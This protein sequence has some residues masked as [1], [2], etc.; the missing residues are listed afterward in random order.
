M[1]QVIA[2]SRK[3]LQAES[4]T[5][6]TMLLQV[7]FTFCP[8]HDHRVAIRKGYNWSGFGY[9]NKMGVA[10]CLVGVASCLVGV[11]LHLVGLVWLQLSLIHT[12]MAILKPHPLSHAH[13]LTN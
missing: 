3:M 12:A 9:F 10:S 11:A 7:H 6:R 1:E 5:Q 13:G 8:N 2:F 4:P